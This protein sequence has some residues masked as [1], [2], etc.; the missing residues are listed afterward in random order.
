MN[1]I[2]FDNNFF[3]RKSVL[4]VLKKRVLGLKEGYRQNLALIGSPYVGKTTILRKFIKDIDDDQL[5]CV[6]LD[7]ENK[8]FYYF[9]H[10]YIRSLLIHYI[11]LNQLQEYDDLNLILTSLRPHLPQTVKVIEQILRLIDKEKIAEAY[12]MLI[13]VPDL[14]T[15]ETGL[16]CLIVL[17]EFHHLEALSIPECFQEL[18][19]KVM[20]QKKC[21]Y[22]ITS[23]FEERANKILSEKLSLLFGN[24]E[25]L[26]VLPFEFKASQ[27]FVESNL[28]GLSIGVQLKSFLADFT[29][30]HPLYMTLICQ[31]I[32]NLGAIHGQTEVYVPLLTQALENVVF[33]RWGVLSRHFELIVNKLSSGKGNREVNALL[34][35]LA[36]GRHKVSELV[37]CMETKQATTK[38]KIQRLIEKDVV[39]RNGNYYFLKDKLFRY[40]IKYVYQR[41]LKEIDPAQGHQTDRFKEEI[42]VAVTHFQNTFAKDFSVRLT[43]LLYCFDNESFQINGRKYKLPMFQSIEPV[44]MGP[45][46]SCLDVIRAVNEEGQWL[47][48]LKQEPVAESDVHLFLQEVKKMAYKPQKCVLVSLGDMDENTR[49]RALQERMWIWNQGDINALMTL[50]DKPNVVK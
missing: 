19:N 9:S 18:G 1:S 12:R 20:T 6:Y 17:D 5:V 41:R 30:G 21:L 3:G 28:P 40:W 33:N 2:D 14:F 8:D 13:A 26:Q 37:N 7:L 29:G 47:V 42:H 22:V 4:E 39:G 43:E 23:S 36:N 10:Q 16:F 24:F 45:D 38:K 44:K 49:V 50:Y 27:D 34:I 32:I 15:A 46:G 11:R 48:A 25:T 35:S 31:E